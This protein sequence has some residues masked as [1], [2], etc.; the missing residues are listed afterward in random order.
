MPLTETMSNTPMYRIQL[1]DY[2][3]G[4][5]IGRFQSDQS[6]ADIQ[7]AM[8]IPRSTIVDCVNRWK[9]TGIEILETRKG[10]QPKL[11]E[12]AQRAVVCSCREDLFMPLVAHTEKMKTA[13]VDIHRQTLIKYAT[14]SG[15]GSYSP[16]YVPKLTPRHIQRRLTHLGQR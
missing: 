13:G 15:F 11:S 5:I 2:T 9:E 7:V 1:D 10:K 8:S 6:R 14:I 16:A 3:C 4:L 12:R